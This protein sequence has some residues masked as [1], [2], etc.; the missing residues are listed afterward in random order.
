MW[1]PFGVLV[2][3][4][5]VELVV[6]EQFV[7][8]HLQQYHFHPAFKVSDILLAIAFLP[9]VKDIHLPV[10]DCQHL[11]L[12]HVVINIIGVEFRIVQ[13]ILNEILQIP[14][15]H[16]RQLLVIQENVLAP[17]EGAAVDRVRG[18]QVSSLS[19]HNHI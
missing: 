15:F 17:G 19:I 16:S 9:D 13:H 10:L 2:L 8:P 18:R 6:L 4:E 14:G 7:R 5:R 12:M 3:F 1:S 11:P